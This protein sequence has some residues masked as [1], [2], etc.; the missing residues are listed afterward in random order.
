MNFPKIE[1]RKKINIPAPKLVISVP[2]P[3]RSSGSSSQIFPY[4]KLIFCK[5]VKFAIFYFFFNAELG[6]LLIHYY[7]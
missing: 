1:L 6:F 5:K 4:A 7:T 3:F 2:I